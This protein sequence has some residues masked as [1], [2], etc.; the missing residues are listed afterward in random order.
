MSA[1]LIIQYVRNLNEQQKEMKLL[2][3]TK[4]K[5]KKEKKRNGAY[6]GEATN[7]KALGRRRNFDDFVGVVVVSISLFLSAENLEG[8]S[9][10]SRD[11]EQKLRSGIQENRLRDNKW[12]KYL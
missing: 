10:L 7:A 9:L 1:N 12:R 2:T 8:R 3:K 4:R 5:K 11:R 6:G